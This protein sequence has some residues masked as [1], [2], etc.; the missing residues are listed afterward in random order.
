MVPGSIEFVVGVNVAEYAMPEP[1]KLESE[2][3]ET[4]TSAAEKSAEDSLS[5]KVMVAVSPLLRAA[6]L[7]VIETVG[8]TVSIE[9]GV[10]SEPARLPLP[11]GSV[12]VLTATETVPGA[13]ELALGVNV[14]E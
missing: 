1:L 4:T 13:V 3:P 7:L 9:I 10:E 2:P 11:A 12:K 14:A 5:V 6:L 8:A